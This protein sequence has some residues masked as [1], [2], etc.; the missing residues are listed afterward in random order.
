[1]RERPIL[2]TGEMVRAILGFRKTQTRRVIKPGK[3]GTP[4][5]DFWVLSQDP[6][7]WRWRTDGLSPASLHPREGLRCP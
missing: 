6:D 3:R 7:G 4:H 2:F 1:M 5:G